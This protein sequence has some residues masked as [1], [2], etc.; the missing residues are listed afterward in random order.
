MRHSGVAKIWLL[1]SSN[2][3]ARQTPSHAKTHNHNQSHFRVVPETDI[4]DLRNDLVRVKIWQVAIL[5][6]LKSE[7]NTIDASLSTT[8]T[9]ADRYVFLF[10]LP[11]LSV[12]HEGCFLVLLHLLSA[13]RVAYYPPSMCSAHSKRATLCL[14]LCMTQFVC[15]LAASHVF[16]R[17]SRTTRMPSG[18]RGV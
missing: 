13:S 9:I 7:P 15:P 1:S 11:A 12:R 6:K 4:Y 17:Y 2:M 10:P 18:R 5:W 3:W 8:L 16:T 14:K